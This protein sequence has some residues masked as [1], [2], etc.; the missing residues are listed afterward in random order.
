MADMFDYLDWF[1]DFDFDHVPFNEVDNI[2]LAHLSYL[3]LDN[4]LP[5]GEFFDT[6]EVW[7]R[8]STQ[9][10]LPSNGPLI[11][12]RT[13]ELL[14]YMVKSGRRFAKAKLGCY[15]THFDLSLIHI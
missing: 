3:K 12:S 8:F 11:S 1:G 13:N 15:E 5:A 7:H 14:G 10:E 2:I 4:I 6:S 9:K